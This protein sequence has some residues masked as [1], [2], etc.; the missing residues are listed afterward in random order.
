M[1]AHLFRIWFIEYF[2][3][4]TETYYSEKKRFLLLFIDNTPGHP[5][6]LMERYNEV[7]IFMPDHTNSILWLMDQGIIQL[8]SFMF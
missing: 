6:A 4:T 2:K 5:R 1:T 8:S 7:N 3:L